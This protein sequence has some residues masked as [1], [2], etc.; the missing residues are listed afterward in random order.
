MLSLIV[1]RK[2]IRIGRSVVQKNWD[3]SRK[4]QTV[5]L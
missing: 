1:L 5:H 2:K 3:W 4:L